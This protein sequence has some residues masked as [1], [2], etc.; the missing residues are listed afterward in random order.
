MRVF[1]RGR[2][3]RP[4]SRYLSS[5]IALRICAE[6]VSLLCLLET[7]LSSKISLE[8]ILWF[9]LKKQVEGSSYLRLERC[10]F[11]LSFQP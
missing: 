4:F 9:F 7:D 1:Y 10:N 6:K 11:F 8:K 2:K 3:E 5:L